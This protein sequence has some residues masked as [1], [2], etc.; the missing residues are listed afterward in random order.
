MRNYVQ[1][2]GHL[3]Q[4]PELRQTSTGKQTAR[5]G[6]ATSYRYRNDAGDRVDRTTWHR[7]VGWNKTAELMST[8]L[9]KG[10]KVMVEGSLSYRTFEDGEGVKRTFTEV[11]ADRFIA[12]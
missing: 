8:L 9:K 1:L 4:D 6:L 11:V 7:V 5:F 10:N 2:I 12:L 3:G